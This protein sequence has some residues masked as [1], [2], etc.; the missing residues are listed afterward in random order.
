MA[1]QSKTPAVTAP[2]A[3]G[4][5]PAAVTKTPKPAPVVAAPISGKPAMIIKE[6]LVPFDTGV[7][8]RAAMIAIICILAAVVIALA[9]VIAHKLKLLRKI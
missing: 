9:A 1:A 4:K 6:V 8:V 5:T 7:G 2:A 3:K